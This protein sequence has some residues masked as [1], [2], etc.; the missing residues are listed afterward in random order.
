MKI[1]DL[2]LVSEKMLS[3]V[4]ED[5]A[6][7]IKFKLVKSNF[8][9]SSIILPSSPNQKEPTKPYKDVWLKDGGVERYKK[10][11]SIVEQKALESSISI[12]WM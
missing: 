1:V 5:G 2:K 9:G 7:C 6:F 12:P 3:G 8:G 10:L 11:V 4:I